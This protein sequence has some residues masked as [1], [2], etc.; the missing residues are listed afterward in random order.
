MFS[1]CVHNIYSSVKLSDLF[2]VIT[3]IPGVDLFIIS[4]ASSSAA[5]QGVPEVEKR[6]FMKGMKVLYVPDLSD[7][8]EVLNPDAHYLIVPS[9]LAEDR[10]DYDELRRSMERG[11]KIV[12]SVSGSESTFSAKELG[13]GRPVHLGVASVLPPTASV[14]I[15]LSHLFT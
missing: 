6:A 15:I 14:A 10:L 12:V 11:D 1:V 4:K 5:Q 2:T 9:R 13:L 3:G 8:N 7:V